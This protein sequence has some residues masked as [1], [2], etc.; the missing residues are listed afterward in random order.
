MKKNIYL[1][2]SNWLARNW[3]NKS[4]YETPK[5]A[6]R[7]TGNRIIATLDLDNRYF[8]SSLYSI[9]PKNEQDQHSLKYYLALLNSNLSTYIIKKIAYELTKGAFTKCGRINYRRYHLEK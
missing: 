5:I 4:F 9:Y 8:L 1:K 2:Y 6:I 7:E 3:K